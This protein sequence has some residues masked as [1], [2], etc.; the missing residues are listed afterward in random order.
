MLQSHFIKGQNGISPYFCL[1]VKTLHLLKEEIRGLY[2]HWWKK[3]KKRNKK[4]REREKKR[5][6]KGAVWFSNLKLAF[7]SEI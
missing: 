6:S 5:K 4:E 7:L 2:S 1:K 3:E